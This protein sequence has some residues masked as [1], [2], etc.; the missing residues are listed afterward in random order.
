MR[1]RRWLSAV[2]L[3]VAAAQDGIAAFAPLLI[4]RMLGAPSSWAMVQAA[5][6]SAGPFGLAS[7][8]ML[9]GFR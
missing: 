4:Q 6:L 7:I 5:L 1:G 2:W 9:V 8:T 3:L